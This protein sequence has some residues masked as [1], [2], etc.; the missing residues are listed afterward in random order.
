MS[1]E[2]TYQAQSPAQGAVKVI[3]AGSVAFTNAA[4]NAL[5]GDARFDILTIATSNDDLRMK[6]SSFSPEAIIIEVTI[7]PSPQDLTAFMNSTDAICY[8]IFPPDVPHETVASFKQHRNCGGAWLGRV[9]F[10]E[11]AQKIRDDVEKLRSAILLRFGQEIAWGTTKIT[12]TRI[13]GVWNQCGGKGGTTIASNLAYAAAR[14]NISTLLV[15]LGGPDDLPLILGLKRVPNILNFRANPGPDGFRASIQKKE[16]LDVI[17]GFPDAISQAEFAMTENL[18]QDFID[19]AIRAGY[20]LIVL[21][22]PQQE[23]APSALTFI[24]QLLLVARP[25]LADVYRTAEAYITVSKKL[26]SKHKLP[27][28]SIRIALN[29]VAP[30]GLMSVEDWR[31]AFA[32]LVRSEGPVPMLSFVNYDKAVPEAQAKGHLPLLVSDRFRQSIIA[33]LHELGLGLEEGKPVE[34]KK[35]KISLGMFTVRW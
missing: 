30:D 7:F 18:F 6:A 27:H 26:A 33:L 2:W 25:T 21:D 32:S 9:S 34:E 3:L 20:A 12:G 1:W 15:G 14:H 13:L 35:K 4:Y 23:I 24:N 10:I 5:A 8:L 22:I 19:Q 28:S 31:A 29:A 16:L 11:M 17:A